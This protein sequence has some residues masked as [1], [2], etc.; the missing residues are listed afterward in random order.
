MRFFNRSPDLEAQVLKRSSPQSRSGSRTRSQSVSQPITTPPTPSF[1]RSRSHTRSQSVAQPAK[2]TTALPQHSTSVSKA[3]TSKVSGSIAIQT[4]IP[5]TPVFSKPA[6]P[7]DNPLLATKILETSPASPLPSSRQFTSVEEKLVPETVPEIAAKH[8]EM[9]QAFLEKYDPGELAYPVPPLSDMNLHRRIVRTLYHD[10]LLAATARLQRH[11]WFAASQ[12]DMY[13]KLCTDN[14]RDRLH[15]DLQRYTQA[16]RDFTYW[17]TSFIQDTDL[18]V[19]PN[20]D[21][22]GRTLAILECA[23]RDNPDADTSLMIHQISTAL[24]KDLA[25]WTEAQSTAHGS[26]EQRLKA[27]YKKRR[28]LN[29][30]AMSTFSGLT[31]ILPM[32]IMVMDPR[33]ITTLVVTSVFTLGIGLILALWMTDAENKDMIGATAAYAA[34]LVVFVGSGSKF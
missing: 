15:E 26:R 24:F 7:Y 10:N 13:R 22:Y 14:R 17:K 1:T 11:I 30:M 4:P 16:V 33:K 27:K 31:L 3:S 29:R 25:D 12:K 28:L 19:P 23:I 8:E 34:V 9:R 18:V 20:F 5:P 6:I 21:T 32:L 2:A